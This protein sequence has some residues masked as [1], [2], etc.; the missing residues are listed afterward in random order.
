MSVYYKKDNP[1]QKYQYESF[2]KKFARSLGYGLVFGVATGIGG[3]GG[4]VGSK[5]YKARKMWKKDWG[6]GR[7]KK[8]YDKINLKSYWKKNPEAK[9]YYDHKI[10]QGNTKAAEYLVKRLR[11]RSFTYITPPNYSLY[12]G[13]YMSKKGKP[14]GFDRPTFEQMSRDLNELNSYSV[15]IA[16]LASSYYGFFKRKKI[17]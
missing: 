2:T 3:Y 1:K 4:L 7:K 10:K 5:Y 12:R 15:P 17:K 11:S 9:R 13:V 8:V 14:L 16:G 6:K